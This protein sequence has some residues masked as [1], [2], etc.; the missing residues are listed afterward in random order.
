[1]VLNSY[2]QDDRSLLIRGGAIVKEKSLYESNHQLAHESGSKSDI[3][4][5]VWTKWKARFALYV[6]SKNDCTTWVV[7]WAKQMALRIILWETSN[8]LVRVKD[9]S[10]RTI[11][12][13]CICCGS[14]LMSDRVDMLLHWPS[15]AQGD[16][17]LTCSF[18]HFR[19]RCDSQFFRARTL[20]RP[21]IHVKPFLISAGRPWSVASWL[22]P[23]PRQIQSKESAAQIVNEG[24]LWPVDLLR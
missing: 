6:D 14:Y 8:F 7:M 4:R 1:M 5:A 20:S 16:T 18:L 11:L 17:F 22:H 15:K 3:A 9:W 13:L 23:L 24:G 10:V 21:G 2:L 12:H 19:Q